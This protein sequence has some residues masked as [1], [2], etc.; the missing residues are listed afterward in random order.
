MLQLLPPPEPGWSGT[1]TGAALEPSLHQRRTVGI[2]AAAG[3]GGGEW[4]G[5]VHTSEDGGE[6]M[7]GES[8]AEEWGNGFLT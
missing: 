5:R 2:A 4:E 1:G 7:S 3:R 6:G 8:R